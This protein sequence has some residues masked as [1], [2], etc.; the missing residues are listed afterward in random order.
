MISKKDISVVIQG[1]I[2]N[3]TYEA[4]DCYQDFGEVIIANWD[5]EDLELLAK[6][7]GRY[8]L[9]SSSYN[10]DDPKNGKMFG[11]YQA[12]TTLAGSKKAKLDYVMKTRSDELYPNLDAMLSNFSEHPNRSHTTDNG[13]WKRHPFC[14]SNHL[15]IDKTEHIVSG[16]EQGLSEKKKFAADEQFFGYYLMRGRGLSIDEENWKE[17]FRENVFITRCIDLP[18]HLHSGQSGAGRYFSRSSDPYPQGRME[19][20]DKAHP[21]DKLYQDIKDIK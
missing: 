4:I 6:C 10:K 17:V 2:D 5:N 3:R 14:Y 19:V 7:K 20:K 18:N 13:F 1:P 11:M 21:A 16:M 8:E 15:F 9:A 12:R